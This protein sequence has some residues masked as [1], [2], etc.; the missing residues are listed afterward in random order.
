MVF[1]RRILIGQ[2]S[3]TPTLTGFNRRSIRPM[4]VIQWLWSATLCVCLLSML[5][6]DK[7]IYWRVLF[8][9][10]NATLITNELKSLNIYCWAVGRCCSKCNVVN[11]PFMNHS[12]KMTHF[13]IYFI[14]MENAEHSASW[15]LYNTINHPH[16]KRLRVLLAPIFLVGLVWMYRFCAY[17]CEYR[18]TD[19]HLDWIEMNY[20]LV[21]FA[22][23]NIFSNP[24][25][26]FQQNM[27]NEQIMKN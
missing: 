14:G 20:V 8:H 11:I 23:V 13:I 9:Y 19:G 24:K 6:H 7:C 16:N 3:S 4:L 10:K 12:N 26:S 21:H 27:F 2:L 17:A 25:W 1:Y 18:I 15:F 5:A 22:Y